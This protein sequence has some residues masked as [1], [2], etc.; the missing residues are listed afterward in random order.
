MGCAIGR[1][2]RERTNPAELAKAED[3]LG[4][5]LLAEVLYCYLNSL[6]IHFLE[7]FS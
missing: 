6:V 3:M 2:L 5:R 4:N 7:T 1:R